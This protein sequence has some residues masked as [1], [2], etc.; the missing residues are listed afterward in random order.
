M[1]TAAVPKLGIEF[2]SVFGLPPV[3]YV[4]LAADL[5][6]AHISTGLYS[7]GSSPHNYPQ[8]S[9]KDDPALRREMIAVLRDRGVSIS[10]GE[11]LSVRPGMEI[12]ARAAEL[13]VMHELGVK[14]INT[15][16]LDPDL[17]RTFDQIARLT[18]MAHALGIET[19]T[20]FGPGLTLGDLP[21]ALAAV[22]H[23]AQPHF[24]LLIDTMHLARTGSGAAD[25]AALPPDMFGY[26]QLSD[27]PR[28]SKFPTYMEEAMYERMVPGTGE[29]PL[30]GILAALPRH[31]VIS[32]EV[33][34]R[35]LA[36]AGE[37]PHER[38]G[39]CVTAARSLL[40]A[41]WKS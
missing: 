27:A 8:W 22:R 1:A 19:T 41:A 18:E 13:A 28:V 36:L 32:L 21:T 23:V 37:G 38:L 14:R 12:S 15:V 11:G 25:L 30:Q 29:L 33:P 10:L 5:G 6:C 31:L 26:V 35:S 39:R 9:L 34:Q 16:S 4:N 40:A 7:F 24:R 17:P 3:Q 20:E 2:L